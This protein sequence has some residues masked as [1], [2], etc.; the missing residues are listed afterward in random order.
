M[1]AQSSVIGA[2]RVT[3]EI[4]QDAFT[5]NR[6]VLLFTSSGPESPLDLRELLGRRIHWMINRA[7]HGWTS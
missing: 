2:H 1:L 3:L 6:Y 7:A 4:N 5:W